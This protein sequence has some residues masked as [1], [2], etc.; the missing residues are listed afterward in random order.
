MGCVGGNDGFAK[1]K[2]GGNKEDWRKAAHQYLVMAAWESY[3]NRNA[4]ITQGKQVHFLAIH[5]C[6]NKQLGE[7][8]LDSQSETGT[9][10]CE[11]INVSE[12][13]RIE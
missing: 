12:P 9:K 13:S 10:S 3:C 1:E 5:S 11:I 8:L 6:W 7:M 2:K 4:E